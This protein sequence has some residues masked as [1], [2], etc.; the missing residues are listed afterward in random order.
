MRGY[1]FSEN[2]EVAHILNLTN[3]MIVV[4]LLWSTKDKFTEKGE[5]IIKEKGRHFDGCMCQWWEDAKVLKEQ[6]FHAETLVP[7]WVAVKG[8]GDAESWLEQ[9]KNEKYVIKFKSKSTAG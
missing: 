5:G 3:K 4:K 1:K 7:W 8:Q 2:D 9:M 6:R